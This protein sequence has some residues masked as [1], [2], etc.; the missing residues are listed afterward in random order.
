MTKKQK[1]EQ[2]K[3]MIEQ[4]KNA[5]DSTWESIKKREGLENG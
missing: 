2:F 4:F 3:K 5:Q 1:K